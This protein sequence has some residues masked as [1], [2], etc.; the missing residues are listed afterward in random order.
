M[1]N[2]KVQPLKSKDELIK[3]EKKFKE[4]HKKQQDLRANRLKE[5]RAQQEIKKIEE[6]RAFDNLGKP[7]SL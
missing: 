2:K 3:D 6:Q 1:K 4:I 5:H 7:V